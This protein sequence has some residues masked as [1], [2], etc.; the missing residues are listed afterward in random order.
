MKECQECRNEL[1]YSGRGRPPTQF[2]SRKC[3]DAS[4]HK[5]R[6]AAAVDEKGERR[7]PVCE[8]V[9]PDTVTLK[10]VCCSRTCGVTYQNR[11]R[12]E[13]KLAR[14][15]AEARRC[16]RCDDPIDPYRH[17]ATKFCSTE[18]KKLE[19]GARW[20][21]KSPGYMRQY[22]YGLSEEMFQE[23]LTAQDGACA[24]CRSTEW[25]GKNNAPHVD[26]CHTTG[27]VR[28]LLCGRCNVGLGQFKDDVQRLRAAIAY[29]ER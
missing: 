28:G 13:K 5:T 26:H 1:V 6:R 18:C 24:I 14:I 20:R 21:A 25:P 8:S 29:L 17:G 4:R 11:V 15:K 27:A 10:A 2:C 23:L 16:I 3:K 9:I 12:A 19:M 7:C 22:M